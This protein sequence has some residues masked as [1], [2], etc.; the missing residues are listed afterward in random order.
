MMASKQSTSSQALTL[1]RNTKAK[2]TGSIRLVPEVDTIGVPVF[3]A[4]RGNETFVPE[5]DGDFRII[6]FSEFYNEHG[7]SIAYDLP[8]EFQDKHYGIGSSAPIP[9]WIENVCFI[10]P[11]DADKEEPVKLF[12]PQ[13][14]T[15]PVLAD[16]ARLLD[17][18]RSGR[19]G[20]R[21]REWTSENIANSFADV[22]HETPSRSRYWVTRYRVAVAGARRMAKPPHPIDNKLRQ[23]AGDWLRRFGSKTDLPKLGGMLGQSAHQIFSKRQ[24]TDILFAFLVSKLAQN[25]VKDLETYAQEPELHKAFSHGIYHHYIDNGWPTVPFHYERVD[26]FTRRMMNAL[27]NCH[28]NEDYRPAAKLAL[29]LYGRAR[30]PQQ[31]ES[32][33]KTY[34]NRMQYQFD[35]VRREAIGIFSD[36]NASHCWQPY[37]EAL[38]DYYDQLMDLEGIIVGRERMKREPYNNRFGVPMQFLKDLRKI[39]KRDW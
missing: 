25:D 38:L 13:A 36:R 19:I 18:A 24:M 5:M 30:L 3:T 10:I 12:G 32:L 34:M 39:K 1:S 21:M 17:D 9:F 23:V 29:L 6:E 22:F 37:A 4:I 26:D 2:L 15:N 27:L 14:L 20:E 28:E 7:Y 35:Q 8:S 16:I 11:G 31:I 33:A